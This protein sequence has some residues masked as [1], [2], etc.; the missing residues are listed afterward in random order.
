MWCTELVEIFCCTEKGSHTSQKQ[1]PTC[2][3]QTLPC[4]CSIKAHLSPCC[5]YRRLVRSATSMA[6]LTFSLASSETKPVP[7]ASTDQQ[8]NKI[9]LSPLD[10]VVWDVFLLPL[11][12]RKTFEVCP[13]SPLYMWAP[14]SPADT[15]LGHQA[16]SRWLC[17]E[18]GKHRPWMANISPLCQ[19]GNIWH[20][21]ACRSL[22]LSDSEPTHTVGVYQCCHGTRIS[23]PTQVLLYYTKTI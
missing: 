22:R 8:R 12:T 9:D 13:S 7:L 15:G 11:V 14:L 3:F 16:A 2:R 5:I 1:I 19:H 10:R 4:M 20:S 23:T 17:G 6:A 21:Q 18:P